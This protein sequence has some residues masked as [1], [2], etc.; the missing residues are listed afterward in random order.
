MRNHIS[1][2]LVVIA[3]VCAVFILNADGQAQ[4]RG[5][6]RAYTKEDVNQLIRRVENRSDEF[7]QVF[8]RALDRSRLDGRNREDRLN[9]RARDLET[10]LDNLRREFDRRERYADTRP[11]VA[12]ALNVAEGINQVMRRRRMGGDAE[13]QWNMLRAELNALAIVYNIRPLRS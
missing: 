6:G 3:A 13:R 7:V 5:R 12:R 8:D 4:R 9:E 1:R 2:F 11:E 10:A